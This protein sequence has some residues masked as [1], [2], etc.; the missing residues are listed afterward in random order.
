MKYFELMMLF[1]IE[2]RAWVSAALLSG[3]LNGAFF[4]EREVSAALFR[5]KQQG[6]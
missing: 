4:R 2:S 1:S 3:A 5:Q 6:D